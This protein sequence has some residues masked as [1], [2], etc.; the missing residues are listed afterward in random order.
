MASASTVFQSIRYLLFE[1]DI[2]EIKKSDSIFEGDPE[3]VPIVL[4]IFDKFF[5]EG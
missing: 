5:N 4:A 3:A 2:D 1:K